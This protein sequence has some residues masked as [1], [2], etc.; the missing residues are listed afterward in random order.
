[1]FLCMYVGVPVCEGMCECV[2]ECCECVC[3]CVCVCVCEFVCDRDLSEL[4]KSIITK[5]CS[6]L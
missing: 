6:S 4:I 5:H 2:F 3:V 1:M